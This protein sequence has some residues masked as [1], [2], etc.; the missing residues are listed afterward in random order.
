MSVRWRK[1]LGDLR[2]SPW[3]AL[4]VCVAIMIGTTAVATTLGARSILSREI[5]ASYEESRPASATLWLDAFDRDLVQL[6]RTRPGV[7]DADARRVVRARV[8]VAPDDWRTLWVF[9]LA[10]F[11]E[12]RVA[13]FHLH[14]GEP[15]TGDGEVL[16][17][18]SALPVLRV[19]LGGTLR[20][21]APGGT[22]ADLRVSGIVHDPGLAPG[23]MDNIGYAYA[24][25]KT[26]AMLG[27]ESWLD[28]LRIV[29][30]GDR[31]DAAHVASD[32]AAWFA[33]RGH[34]VRRIEV[35]VRQHFHA[36]Q[37]SAVL[38][39]LQTLSL[40]ALLLS[41]VLALNVM[42]ALVAKQ[43]RQIGIMKAVGAS[44]IQVAGIYLGYVF[45]LAVV[46]I[47]I[48][49]PIGSL[50]ARFF[51][52]FAAEQLNLEVVSR[53]IPSYV[54]VLEA[55]LGLSIPLV[56]AFIPVLRAARVPARETIQSVGLQSPSGRWVGQRLIERL[57]FDRTMILSLRN[58]LRRPV[59]LSLTLG[60][61]ALGGAVLMTALNVYGSLVRAVDDA[62]AA[63]GGDVDVLLHRPA[64]AEELVSRAL[65]IPGVR[66]AEAWGYA[67]AAIELP[68]SQS[69][70]MVGTER[71]NLLAPPA[72]TRL[73]HLPLAEGRLPRPNE[74]GAV[75]INGG[76]R[77][78]EPG[79][80]LGAGSELTLL[81]DGR[82]TSVR[83]VGVIA[84]VGVPTVY[85]NTPTMERIIGASGVAAAL[86]ITTDA[87]ARSRVAAQLENVLANAGLFPTVMMTRD[88]VRQAMT[89]H[90]LILLAILIVAALSAI[91]VGGLGLATSMSL[92]VLERSR[93]I[94]VMRAIGATPRTVLRVLLVEGVAVAMV[95][96]V[97]AVLVSLPLS[98]A[99]GRVIGDV[100]LHVKL[101]FVVSSLGIA[102][103]VC[104]AAIITTLACF[105]PAVSAL[106]L[107]VRDVLARE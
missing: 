11:R 2:E 66:V 94:G 24:A 47:L 8:E 73:F 92:N 75:A 12:I 101:P 45:I 28:E 27:Q 83:V 68:R 106:R 38:A 57:P 65:S 84:E 53:A 48:A 86:R 102:G 39:L 98:A 7:V 89:D 1:V 37:M 96:V 19:G 69:G 9:G 71:F 55:A 15:P 30:G 59:R 95:S 23:W 10:D 50:T 72:D 103:W 4:L 3:R 107:S 88:A 18:R 62:L 43:V 52:S 58:T 104:L 29:A 17:E 105:L 46:A 36:D 34:T 99:V 54:F 91:V 41:G 67:L 70:Q 31:E 93:E 90:F 79:L 40:L 6:A 42:A 14:E 16:V 5:E 26:L 35:P 21:R 61:L 76:L 87:E 78:R 56:G 32:L 81:V 100:G 97:L 49:V 60:A 22:T 63:R 20:V 77:D 13:T 85:T 25:P 80:R 51:A 64:R 82:R 44:T 74:S 33:S